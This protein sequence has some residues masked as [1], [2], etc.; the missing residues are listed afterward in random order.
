MSTDGAANAPSVLT[1]S[2]WLN[3]DRQAQTA[4]CGAGCLLNMKQRQESLK[5]R[6]DSWKSGKKAGE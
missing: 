6:Q 1:H 3:S 5:Q 4:L 2:I